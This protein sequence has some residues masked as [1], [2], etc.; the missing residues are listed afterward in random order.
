MFY[1]LGPST[2]KQHLNH[3]KDRKWSDSAKWTQSNTFC[4][5]LHPV[6]SLRSLQPVKVGL[7]FCP[8]PFPLIMSS[9][10]SL[11]NL[12][13]RTF[14][15]AFL[16]ISSCERA[17]RCRKVM[18]ILRRKSVSQLQD[19]KCPRA[20]KTSQK[21]SVMVRKPRRAPL[22]THVFFPVWCKV[23]AIFTLLHL[24][25]KL[26]GAQNVPRGLY[27][28]FSCQIQFFTSAAPHLADLTEFLFFSLWVS[29]SCL[30]WIALFLV[31]WFC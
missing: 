16:L 9:W 27:R 31:M 30:A 21:Q 19:Q 13:W 28:V 26:S 7:I 8:V 14:K 25:E 6:S 20:I 18:Q 15:A 17:T 11:M 2:F 23:D 4:R 10:V 5:I 24:K 3:E 12:N 29:V 1:I 22:K